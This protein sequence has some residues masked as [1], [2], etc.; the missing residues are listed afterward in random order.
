MTS[1]QYVVIF[2]AQVVGLNCKIVEYCQ[3]GIITEQ[4][5]NAKGRKLGALDH[6]L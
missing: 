4:G 5:T 6:M 1:W 3:K 2:D